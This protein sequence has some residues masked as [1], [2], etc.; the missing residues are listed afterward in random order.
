M[1]GTTNIWVAKT[2]TAIKAVLRTLNRESDL[3]KCTCHS[4]IRR[5]V[6]MTHVEGEWFCSS[7]AADQWWHIHAK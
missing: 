5:T 6:D 2:R 3:E 4:Q 7:E 1:D